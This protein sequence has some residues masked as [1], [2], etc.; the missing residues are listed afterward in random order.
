MFLGEWCL[1]NDER[2][3]LSDNGPESSERIIIFSTD[4]CLQLLADATT[5]YIDGNFSLAPNLFTQL[6][7]IRIQKNDIFVSVVYCLLQ[8]K[9]QFTYEEL[10]NTILKECEVREIY[11]DPLYINMDFEIAAM[12][13]IKSCLGTHVVL[14][15]CFYH[16]CQSTHRKIQ[17]LGLEKKY[18]EDEYF[19]HYCSMLDGLAFVP[20]NLVQEAMNILK[21]KIPIG[22]ESIVDYFNVNYVEGT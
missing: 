10:F 1:Y 6:Y 14:R 2:F 4:D 12:Q 19:N 7:I 21:M 15:G 18:R 17:Q 20:L 5:W 8:T 22:A 3:L 9:T 13:A 16:L 11:P